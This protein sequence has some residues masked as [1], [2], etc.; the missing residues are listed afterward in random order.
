MD[1]FDPCGIE[2]SAQE[3]VVALSRDG[4]AERLRSFPNTAEGHAALLRYLHSGSQRVR[5]ALESTG[6]YGLDLAYAL[7]RDAQIE[8]MVANPR[9]VRHFAS[10]LMQR[11]KNDR[12]DAEVLRSL[13][14]ACRFQAWVAPSAHCFALC[15]VTRRLETLTEQSTAEKNRLHAASLSVAFPPAVRRDLQRSVRSI[16]RALAR[17]TRE[18]QRILE[19][20]PLLNSS[21]HLLLTAKGIGPTSALRCW[22]RRRCCRKISTCANGWPM[23]VWTPVNINRA[24]RS[25]RKYASAN[26]QSTPAPGLVHARSGRR[27]S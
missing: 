10:A 12:L 21:Y 16:Q 17:L 9:A 15:A 20:D 7:H 11:S 4:R 13:R 25:T 18:A 8:V 1:K 2:V 27:A 23:P 19:Q 14:R 22:P 26:G 5:V 3:L 24:A 6:L